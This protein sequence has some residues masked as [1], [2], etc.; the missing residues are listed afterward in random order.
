MMLNKQKLGF[1]KHVVETLAG[2]SP[3]LTTEDARSDSSTLGGAYQSSHLP[4][5]IE[6]F[7]DGGSARNFQQKRHLAIS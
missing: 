3:Q 7:K 6:V 4:A 5:E 1:L 2:F